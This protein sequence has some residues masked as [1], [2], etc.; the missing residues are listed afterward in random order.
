VCNMRNERT[1]LPHRMPADLTNYTRAGS[2]VVAR[3]VNA[4]ED[5]HDRVDIQI[6]TGEGEKSGSICSRCHQNTIVNAVH[7]SWEIQNTLNTREKWRIRSSHS[8]TVTHLHDPPCH[9]GI[10]LFLPTERRMAELFI[11]MC[12]PF[13][14]KE[15]GMLCD[16]TTAM[17]REG[18]Q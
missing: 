8:A 14:L 5:E 10:H 6:I 13:A 18:S 3:Y 16:S 7:S 4:S 15:F 11:R 12:Y 1:S 9:Q 17:C 2:I